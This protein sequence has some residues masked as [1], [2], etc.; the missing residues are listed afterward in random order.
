[1]KVK[2]KKPILGEPIVLPNGEFDGYE[3]LDYEDAE[4]EISDKNYNIL[5]DEYFKAFPKATLEEFKQEYI[6]PMFER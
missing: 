5:Y 6:Y 1:M 3:I 2:I 4:V